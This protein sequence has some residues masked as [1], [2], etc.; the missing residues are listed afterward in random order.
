MH[1]IKKQMS[2]VKTIEELNSLLKNY[3]ASINIKSFAFTYYNQHTKTGSKLVYDWATTA[4]EAW[5]NF[6]L[7]E[8]YADIDR[9]LES[10][11][12]SLLP[13]FWDV[14]EQLRLATNKRVQ[15]FKQES[16]NFGLDK[17]LCIPLHGPKGEFVILVLH[18][19]INESGLT[20][21]ED[22][23]D[24]WLGLL[25]TYFHFL[26]LLLQEKMIGEIP[27]T[28]REQECLRL[29]AEGFR[30]ELIAKSLKISKRTV[31]FHLQNANKKLG[32]SN[33]YLAIMSL[34]TKA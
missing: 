24:T 27:L 34:N 30:L 6:Y 20:N 2:E 11:E 19:R 12:Q 15:R 10:T 31:N 18:Q 4:L 5:H 29:T 1:I 33:K 26:R 3:F 7:Q 22:H 21:W 28:K 14:K 23:L 9:I 16:I 17:G 25:H 13:V 32:V 8:G